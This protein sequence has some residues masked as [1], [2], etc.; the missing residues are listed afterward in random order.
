ME[1]A[2]ANGL[3]RRFPAIIPPITRDAVSPAQTGAIVGVPK[4][5]PEALS[6][7]Q[8][9]ATQ[10]TMT[11]SARKT[12]YL[13]ILDDSDGTRISAAEDRVLACDADILPA[14]LGS[15]SQLLD[16]GRGTRPFTGNLRHAIALRDRGCVFPDC[17]RTTPVTD[18]ASRTSRNGRG[19]AP[20]R[21]QPRPSG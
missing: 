13:R 11:G 8:V 15:T 9:Q 7:E 17:H 18:R 10:T 21:G 14:I 20:S 1:V 12:Q 4:K 3:H 6:T 19:D 2:L 16:L 5:L